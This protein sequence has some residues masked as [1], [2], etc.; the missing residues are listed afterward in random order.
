MNTPSTRKQR[1]LDYY[2]RLENGQGSLAA[3]HAIE[4]DLADLTHLE[5]FE[6]FN[7]RLKTQEPKQILVY[8]DRVMH[9]VTTVLKP[10]AVDL[11]KDSILDVLQQENEALKV[12]L[13]AI[14]AKLQ[15]LPIIPTD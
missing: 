5:V 1:L 6:L 8:V 4:S 3:Y 15:R 7:E 13:Q 2:Q 11:P 10:K 9:V 14:Q 12:R